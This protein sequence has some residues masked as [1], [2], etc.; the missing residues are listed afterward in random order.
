M[1][2]W[3]VDSLANVEMGSSAFVL[4]CYQRCLVDQFLPFGCGNSDVEL[5]MSF[6]GLAL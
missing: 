2:C 6:Y 3:G 1:H 5:K 4:G